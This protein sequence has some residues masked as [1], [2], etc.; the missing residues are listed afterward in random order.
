MGSL[1]FAAAELW[2]RAKARTASPLMWYSV[3]QSRGKFPGRLQHF[4][5]LRVHMAYPPSTV[6]PLSCAPTDIAAA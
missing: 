6:G 1:H 2:I 3:S 4:N 5:T